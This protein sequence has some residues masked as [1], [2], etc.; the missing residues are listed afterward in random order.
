MSEE[1]SRLGH[2]KTLGCPPGATEDEVKKAWQQLSMRLHPDRNADRDE[3][4]TEAMQCV[5][6]AKQHLRHG[7]SAA[8]WPQP[9]ARSHG[10]LLPTS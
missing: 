4:A 1:M 10:L 6:L 3:L 2:L 8:T 9:L 7:S 5:N